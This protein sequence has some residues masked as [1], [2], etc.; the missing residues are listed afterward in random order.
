LTFAFREAVFGLAEIEE[1]LVE[2][3]ASQIRAILE[4]AMLNNPHYWQ[5]Y[6]A[7]T[8]KHQKIARFYSFS[9]RIRYYWNTP[10]VQEALKRLMYNLEQQALPFSLLSQY[11]PD[12]YERVRAGELSSHPAV[13]II[14]RVMQV[15]EDYRYACSNSLS[16]HGVLHL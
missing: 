9:D 13:L 4:N 14:D 8:P 3:G 11:L 12:Q 16:P 6:Y 7:G 10:P 1:N 15:L 2:E 5:N